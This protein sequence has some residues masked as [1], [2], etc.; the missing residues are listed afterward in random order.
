MPRIS[1]ERRAANRA[2]IVDAA[3]RCFARDGFHQTSMPDIVSEA[4][5]SAGA[6]YRYFSSKEELVR[7]IAREAFGG[8]GRV[9]TELLAH[10]PSPSLPEVL[11]A[12]A[13]TLSAP[14]FPAGD[15]YVDTEEQFRV[16][17]QAW[18]ELLRDPGLRAEA[19]HGAE[20]FTARVAEALA[21][22]QAAGRVPATLDPH[23][24]ASLVFGLLPGLLL[25]RAVLGR[26]PA[27]A[28]RAVTAL[29]DPHTSPFG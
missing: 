8:L 11:G 3:R 23:D 9:V 21:R 6:F 16:A 1:E 13:A 14:T 4:G 20:F 10:D 28:V 26:D 7:E 25:W 22:G 15:R 19:S 18:G 17:I 12:V 5:I 27:A 2:A 29:A 24:G